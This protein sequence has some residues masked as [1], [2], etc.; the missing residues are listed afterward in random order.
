MKKVLFFT[1]V[2]ILFS[3]CEKDKGNRKIDILKDGYKTLAPGA[4]EELTYPF[5]KEDTLV[6]DANA[7]DAIYCQGFLED[8]SDTT[9]LYSDSLNVSPYD[10]HN[11]ISI[12]KNGI[13]TLIIQNLSSDTLRIY[14]YYV[15]IRWE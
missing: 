13:A 9:I 15:R 11:T 10:Y 3:G 14:R 2:L 6:V 12:P 7:N 4:Q 8:N 5:L 1:G